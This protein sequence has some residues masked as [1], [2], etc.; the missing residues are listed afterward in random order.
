[1]R[2]QLIPTIPASPAVTVSKEAVLEE[3]VANM[4]GV[5]SIVVELRL[6][7]RDLRVEDLPGLTWSGSRL[8]LE[9]V[10]KQ[11]ERARAG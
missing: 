11:L 7:V 1:V 3:A 6:T 5:H 9:S 10:A 8:H 4:T 2:W